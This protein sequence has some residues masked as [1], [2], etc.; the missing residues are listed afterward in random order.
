M[1]EY[2]KSFIDIY[3]EKDN[4]KELMWKVGRYYKI[5][6]ETKNY[7]F[8]TNELIIKEFNK[9]ENVTSIPNIFEMMIP[10]EK[11]KRTRLPL[12]FIRLTEEEVIKEIER[13]DNGKSK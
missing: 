13:I 7:I 1:V 5:L 3:D 10:L 8:P 4:K 12:G 2:L 9:Y 6:D 11:V